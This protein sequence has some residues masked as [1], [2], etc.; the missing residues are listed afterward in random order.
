[1]WVELFKFLS[2]LGRMGALVFSLISMALV[3]VTLVERDWM[4]GISVYIVVMGVISIFASLIPPYPNFIL[5]SFFALSWFIA[6][7]FSFLIMVGE[8]G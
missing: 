8:L 2:V 7:I 5:D 3:A 4:D 1:M 6:A